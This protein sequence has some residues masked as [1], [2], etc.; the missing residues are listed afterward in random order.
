MSTPCIA[1]LNLQNDSSWFYSQV[2]IMPVTQYSPLN[3]ADIYLGKGIKDVEN[4]GDPGKP[5]ALQ[6]MGMER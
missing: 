6:L 1:V 4:G 2:Y 5:S 3:F